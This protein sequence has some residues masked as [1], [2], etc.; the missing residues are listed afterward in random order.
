MLSNLVGSN[1]FRGDL[2]TTVLRKCN[3]VKLEVDSDLDGE[4][5]PEH[6]DTQCSDKIDTR[7]HDGG[8][9]GKSISYALSDDSPIQPQAK[10]QDQFELRASQAN[11]T[12]G[13]MG[14]TAVGGSDDD[15]AEL[16]AALY[17]GYGTPADEEQKSSATEAA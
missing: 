1:Q 14:F 5:T 4:E 15:E 12:C 7:L 13:Q 11:W 2:S 6:V 9:R 17:G 10:N 3:N 8:V 16:A